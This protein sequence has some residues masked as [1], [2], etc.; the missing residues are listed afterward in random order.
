MSRQEQHR[1]FQIANAQAL[2]DFTDLG[3]RLAGT[4]T[5]LKDLEN[6]YAG[7]NTLVVNNAVGA[8][9]AASAQLQLNQALGSGRL[10]GEEFNSINEATPQLLTEVA[11]VMGV[12]RGELKELAADGKITSDILIKALTNIKEKGADQ[13]E[14]S[15]NTAAGD[16]RKFDKAAK[17]LQV[18]VGQQLLPVFT[19]L[20]QGVTKL[21]QGFAQLP[22][23]I[24]QAAVGIAVL[25]VAV[26]GL[27]IALNALGVA[28]LGAAFSAIGAAATGLATQL[29]VVGAKALALSQGKAVLAGAIT[30]ANTKVTLLTVGLGALKVAMLALPW[31]ALAAGVVAIGAAFVKTTQEKKRFD[32]LL[33][34]GSVDDLSKE[35]DV[36]REK[37]EAA[38]KRLV[39]LRENG[40]APASRSMKRQQAIVDE[41]QRKLDKIQGTYKV[42]IEIEQLFSGKTNLADIK[43]S[44]YGRGDQGLTYKVGDIT[45]DART[46]K[47]IIKKPQ[48]ITPPTGGDSGGSGKSAAD[49]LKE[50]MEAGKELS[51]EFEKQKAL[52]SAK[53]ELQRSLIEKDYELLDIERQI[54][55][56]TAASQQA[57][58]L[59]EAQE[60]ASLQ[61]KQLIQ[62]FSENASKNALQSAQ[63]LIDQTNQQVEADRRRT[64]LITQGINPALADELVKIEQIFEAELKKLDANIATLESVKNEIKAR[65]QNVD[66]I[67]DE[68][69]AL[70]KKRKELE[71]A[72]K[73]QEDGA[74][75]DQSVGG[76]LKAEVD[77]QKEALAEL[78]DPV[79]QIV[80]AANAIG[81]AFGQAFS[82]IVSGSKSAKQAFADMF[83]KIGEYFINMAA[84]M[85][86]EY[87]QLILMQT[88][89]NAIGGPALGGGGGGYQIPSGAAPKTSGIK[90]FAEGGFTDSPTK[91]MIGEG[92]DSEYIIPSQKMDSAM[93]R[94]NAGARGSSVVEGASRYQR[95]TTQDGVTDYMQDN[96]PVNISTGPVMQFEGRNYVTQEEFAAGVRSAAK[97]GEARALRRLQMSPSARRKAGVG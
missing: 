78:M 60:I 39:A 28:G 81:D 26:G 73:A 93:Q 16:L 90:F 44:G 15:F 62:Q 92:G 22:G 13:L 18:T 45:Y 88:I 96:M 4:G 55:E 23:P 87:V 36:L 80:G 85:I 35:S 1:S 71:G 37:L 43:S 69:D 32:E 21:A 65:G 49:T 83:K 20:L 70:K 41:L 34:S 63:Q 19:P 9:Q 51:R 31:V 12:A 40:V 53:N 59:A 10:A 14:D 72:Q 2:S 64:E 11:R 6:I 52:L 5:T 97:Q 89:L 77:K 57:G 33:R 91:A 7:F 50:Q 54:K 75:G 27:N 86:A 42:R 84:K 46:G 25:T 30:A 67:E 17:D 8:Q 68:I 47:P 58:L 82:D 61:R 24:Q 79:N 38:E 94:Y 76:R 3:N 74:K 66:A 29:G 95:G 56:T 48:A